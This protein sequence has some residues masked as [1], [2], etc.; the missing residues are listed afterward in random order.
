MDCL[1]LVV[2]VVEDGLEGVG[3][4]GTTACRECNHRPIVLGL[5]VEQYRLSGSKIEDGLCGS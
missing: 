3:A 4:G 5:H 1:E 2:D